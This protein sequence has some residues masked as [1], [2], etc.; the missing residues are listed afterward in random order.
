MSASGQRNVTYL[1]LSSHT[2]LHWNKIP[3]SGNHEIARDMLAG[4][5]CGVKRDR[6]G[7]RREQ[8]QH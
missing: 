3:Y 8:Q 5:C 4:S 1:N 7:K 6:K 2:L